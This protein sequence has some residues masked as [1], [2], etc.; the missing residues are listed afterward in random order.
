MKNIT[1]LLLILL[2]AAIVVF[3]AEPRITLSMIMKNEAHRYLKEVLEDAVH[4]IDEAVI[5]DD[6]SSDESIAIC[7]EVLKG[8]PHRVIKNSQST[9]ANEI[10]L[11]KQQWAE[12]IKTNP[13]WILCLDADEIFECKF[14]R[15]IK[16]LLATIKEDTVYFRLYSDLKPK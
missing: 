11:R 10:V 15:V 14:R 4:Y 3:G 8:I 2:G 13:E 1:I 9:F 12:T 16:Q 7:H 6:N 5:I